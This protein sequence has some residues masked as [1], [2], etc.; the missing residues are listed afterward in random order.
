ME[1]ATWLFP[2]TPSMR[3]SRALIATLATFAWLT[4]CYQSFGPD[5]QAQQ[6]TAPADTTEVDAEDTT[7]PDTPTPDTTTPDT[8]TPDTTTPDTIIQDSAIEIDAGPECTSNADCSGATP[9]CDRI[10][11][12]CV[13]CLSPLDC[14]ALRP[15]CAPTEDGPR[16]ISGYNACTR[17]DNHEDSNDGPRGATRLT[18]PESV[19]G[20][21]CGEVG[22]PSEPEQDWYTFTLDA[23]QSVDITL[24]WPDA[25]DDL[26][27]V[28]LDDALELLPL[29]QAGASRTYP[30]SLR[31]DDLNAGTY[32]LVVVSLQVPATQASPYTLAI[33]HPIAC[34]DD[35]QCTNPARPL[36]DTASDRCVTCLALT[37]CPAGAPICTTSGRCRVIDYCTGDDA[38]EHDDDGPSG[39]TPVSLP[40]LPVEGRICGEE[41]ADSAF[42]ADWFQVTL[43]AGVSFTTVLEWEDAGVDLNAYLLD[44]DLRFIG[45]AETALNPERIT[46]TPATDGTHYLVVMSASGAATDAIAYSLSFTLGTP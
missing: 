5:E 11:G 46:V 44:A 36:C 29:P 15:V 1:Q 3:P 25:H 41:G 37:D 27:F 10:R 14:T 45:R 39:A 8:T 21:I 9:V 17:D 24:S 4:G 12:I 2:E 43:T 16:C 6:D 20:R 13:G 42:E 18:V 28:L 33:G 31:V 40:A 7:T 38:R 19:E 30:A 32:Y 22:T 35:R 23:S 26:S 34:T